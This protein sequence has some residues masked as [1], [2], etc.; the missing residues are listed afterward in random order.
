[1]FLANQKSDKF[2]R[3]NKYKELY[4]YPYITKSCVCLRNEK[5]EKLF[6]SISYLIAH[7]LFSIIRTAFERNII[8]L[9]KTP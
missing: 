6:D 9:S 5:I 8:I 4:S 7:K 2:I 1:M 3:S